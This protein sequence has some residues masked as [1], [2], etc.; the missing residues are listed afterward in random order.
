MYY[1]KNVIFVCSE[2]YLFKY[3]TNFNALCVNMFKKYQ[4]YFIHTYVYV[5]TNGK[6]KGSKIDMDL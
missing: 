4:F 6:W 3:N 5:Y 2:K 1:K